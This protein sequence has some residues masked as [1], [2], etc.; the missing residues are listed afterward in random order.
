MTQTKQQDQTT[1]AQATQVTVVLAGM[2]LPRDMKAYWQRKLDNAI[3]FIQKGL[4]NDQHRPRQ[5]HRVE[6]GKQ[7]ARGGWSV[8]VYVID[9]E[10]NQP[11]D[12]V[13]RQCFFDS[14]QELLGYVRA[15]ASVYEFNT[16]GYFVF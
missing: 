12:T 9:P 8:C 11:L 14:R 3:K 1:Q 7:D 4:L 2:R 6:I 5:L 16:D 13:F 10:T 15:L